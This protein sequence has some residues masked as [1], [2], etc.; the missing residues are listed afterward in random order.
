MFGMLESLTKAA[1]GVVTTPVALVADA[2]TLGGAL[3]EQEK[4]YTAQHLEKVKDNLDE[5]L[6]PKGYKE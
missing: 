1:V 2:I 4:P 3:T 6:E 5:A